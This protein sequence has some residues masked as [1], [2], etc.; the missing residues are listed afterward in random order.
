MSDDEDFAIALDAFSLFTLREKR[1]ALKIVTELQFVRVED[2]LSE[3]VLRVIKQAQRAARE[4][5]EGTV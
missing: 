4:A 2:R 1:A 3:A 5:H